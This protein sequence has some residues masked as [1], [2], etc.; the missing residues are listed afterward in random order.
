VRTLLLL[1]PESDLSARKFIK[2]A[3]TRDALD[4]RFTR[5]GQIVLQACDYSVESVPPEYTHDLFEQYPYWSDRLY[6]LLKEAND[7]SPTTWYEHWSD[8][9]KSPRYTYWAG[10]IALSL[11]LFFGV[12]ATILGALQVWISY[13]SWQGDAAGRVCKMHNRG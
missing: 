8:R 13:C 4:S 5:L 6:K 12:L 11:A 9:K 2:Q 1:F 10:I 7:P 3:I